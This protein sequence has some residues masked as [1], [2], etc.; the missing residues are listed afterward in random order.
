MFTLTISQIEATI[1]VTIL[2]TDQSG[3]E[4]W[5]EALN[6]SHAGWDQIFLCNYQGAQYLLRYNPHMGQGYCTYVFSLFSPEAGGKE[7]VLH[8]KTLEFDINGKEEL[9]AKKMLAFADEINSF[10]NKSRLLVSSDGGA[11]NFG[12]SSAEPFFEYYSWLDWMPELYTEGDSLEVKLNK[13]IYRRS[14]GE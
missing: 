14:F 1:N 2:V 10:L 13:Y 6:T 9:D 12:L 11:W 5:R 8:T 4:L 3:N 7:N